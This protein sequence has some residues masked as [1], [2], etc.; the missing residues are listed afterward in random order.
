MDYI[1]PAYAS[2][3]FCRTH[4]ASPMEFHLI[5]LTNSEPTVYSGPLCSVLHEYV[6]LI[7]RF[8]NAAPPPPP[9]F[10]ST[11]IVDINLPGLTT[12]LS[13]MVSP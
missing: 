8:C 6:H 5:V 12:L 13:S 7:Q 10:L 2:Y 9:P 3:G 11:S 1:E 4:F